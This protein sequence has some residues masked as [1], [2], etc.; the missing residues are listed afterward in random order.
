[1]R[2]FGQPSFGIEIDIV[3]EEDAQA[4]R[5]LRYMNKHRV[6]PP[7]GASASCGCFFWIPDAKVRK[8]Y[9]LIEAAGLQHG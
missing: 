5:L 8:A 4:R 6:P 9:K 7:P 3:G 2:I 1:M